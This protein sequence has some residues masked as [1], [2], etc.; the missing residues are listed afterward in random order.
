MDKNKDLIEAQDRIDKLF[1]YL[2]LRL[3]EKYKDFR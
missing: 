3:E 2:H 1:K